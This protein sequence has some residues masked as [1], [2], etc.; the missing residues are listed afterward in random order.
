M[1]A[2]N[3]HFFTGKKGKKSAAP[4]TKKENG[5]DKARIRHVLERTKKELESC[6]PPALTP[7]QVPFHRNPKRQAILT[8]KAC[9]EH[10]KTLQEQIKK[11]KEQIAFLKSSGLSPTNQVILKEAYEKNIVSLQTL[12]GKINN[13]PENLDRH[14]HPNLQL[15]C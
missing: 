4:K 2:P 5:V 14:M 7:I 12:I 9:D 1:G 6:P 8:K 3:S 10:V 13:I 15:G 11:T